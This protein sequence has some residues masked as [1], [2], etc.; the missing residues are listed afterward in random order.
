MCGRF[1]Q[2]YTWAEVHAF[3]S[4]LGASR[5]LQPHYNIAPTMVVD[6][7]RLGKHGRELV[8]MRWGLI[9]WWWKK[10]VKEM[11][12]TFN[13][14]A[15]SV[16]DK[17]MFRNAFK[18]RRCII[19]AS[20]FFEWTGEK[21]SKQPH[22]FTAADGSP[23]LAFAGLWDRWRDPQSGDEV[24][25]CTI[26]VSGASAWMEPYHDRMPVL[27][28]AK[29]FDAWLDGSLGP[30]ALKPATESALRE[31]KVSPHMNRTGVGDD[32][33]TVIEPL[34]TSLSGQKHEAAPLALDRSA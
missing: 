23:V 32:D 27:L 11:P 34:V 31:W 18:D 26:I 21:G 14:R 15:E 7:I 8:P 28:E 33:P 29:D 20:G 9:P 5:N 1:T 16:A 6:V 22:L 4:V 17:P 24:L 25:S 3:S 13:A 19:P 10:P 12:A 2:N 30:E